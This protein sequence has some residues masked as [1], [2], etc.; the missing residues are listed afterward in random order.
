MMLYEFTKLLLDQRE[1]ENLVFMNAPSWWKTDKENHEFLLEICTK[2]LWVVVE[3]IIEKSGLISS[4]DPTEVLAELQGIKAKKKNGEWEEN[5]WFRR[6]LQISKDFNKALMDNVWI[7]NL[8]ENIKDS[9]KDK[10]PNGLFYIDDGSCRTLVCALHN[11]LK[12]LPY[13]PIEAIH[14]TSWDLA[15]GI[16]NFLPQNA[17]ALINS[18]QIEYDESKHFIENEQNFELPIG[19]QIHINNRRNRLGTP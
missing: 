5:P 6:H 4:T 10:C 18:G 19:I 14:A 17:Q 16:L 13:H 15:S 9:E 12:G 3:K 2:P 11:R 7:R 1:F 8:S